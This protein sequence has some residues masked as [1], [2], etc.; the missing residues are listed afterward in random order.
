M[1]VSVNDY[2]DDIDEMVREAC[3]EEVLRAVWIGRKHVQL[4][5]QFVS[6]RKKLQILD[7][8]VTRNNKS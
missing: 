8:D 7:I 4:L 2:L 5:R 1:E 3:S 6:I